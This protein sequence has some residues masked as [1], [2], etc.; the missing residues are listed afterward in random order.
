MSVQSPSPESHD[1]DPPEYE[2]SYSN[3]DEIFTKGMGIRSSFCSV[4]CFY[5]HRGRN[6]L[7]KIESDHR[8][9]AT[10]FRRVKTTS[11]PSEDWADRGASPMDAALANGAVLANA[12]GEITLDATECSD[13]RPTATDSA[14]G[15]QYPTPE[16]T[17]VVDIVAGENPYSR[18]ERGG[19][20]CR[21]GN[22]D[23]GERHAV[24]EDVEIDTILP[25]LWRCLVTLVEAGAIGPDDV[26]V[27]AQLKE[28]LLRGAREHWRDWEFTIGY[29]LYGAGGSDP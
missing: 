13:A 16:T 1:S 28:R 24:L 26:D 23:L 21:C 6:A 25:S 17:F 19:W 29:T 9:C 2:C 27:N 5:R 3:C 7:N 15:Y 8:F 11:E 14:V 12:G 20:G 18:I 22:V 10:C 4:A